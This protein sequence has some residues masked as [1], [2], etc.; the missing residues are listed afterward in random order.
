M[1]E[2]KPNDARH[3]RAF[4]QL[5][6]EGGAGNARQTLLAELLEAGARRF[7]NGSCRD[8]SLDIRTD[9]RTGIR[10]G[11]EILPASRL[12]HLAEGEFGEF[13]SVRASLLK[14]VVFSSEAALIFPG[15]RRQVSVVLHFR[16][17]ECVSRETGPEPEA[18]ELVLK[19]LPDGRFFGDDGYDRSEL[20]AH[21]KRLACLNA[22]LALT[23]GNEIF[24]DTDGTAELFQEFFPHTPPEAVFTWRGRILEFSIARAGDGGPGEIRSFAGARETVDGGI[25][26]D[27]FK[28]GMIDA[29]ASRTGNFVPPEKFFRGWN[30]VLAAHLDDPMFESGYRCRLGGDLEAQFRRMTA[31]AL[32]RELRRDPDRLAWQTGK[33]RT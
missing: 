6:L 24:F 27:G 25:H 10:F 23:F 18:P 1:N 4:P 33:R 30:V 32:E 8:I 11:G 14:A 12:E 5:L 29:F 13:D 3:F 20:R 2:K 19:Y 15:E 28:K 22:G 16:D 26:V 21:L 31:S 17:G 9:G 7:R